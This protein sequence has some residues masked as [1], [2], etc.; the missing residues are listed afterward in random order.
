MLSPDLAQCVS[1]SDVG[2]W[3]RPTTL[4]CGSGWKRLVPIQVAEIVRK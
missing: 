4:I 1:R 3:H 2:D